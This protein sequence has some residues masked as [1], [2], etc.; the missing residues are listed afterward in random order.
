M[1]TN[2]IAIPIESGGLRVSIDNAAGLLMRR[3]ESIAS[4][5]CVFEVVDAKDQEKAIGTM[6]QLAAVAS[7]VE[8]ARKLVKGPLLDL[9]RKIDAVCKEFVDDV[10]REKNRIAKLAADWQALED[11]KR[12]AAE[13]AARMEQERIAREAMRAQIE[14]ER[15][16]KLESDRIERERQAALAAAKSHEDLDRINAEAGEQ[17]RR[18]AQ[19]EAEAK[20]RAEY[21][22]AQ[23]AAAIVAPA[24]Q[25]QI[26]GQ[27][28]TQDWE[29]AVT[30]IHALYRSHPGCVKMT[31]LLGVIKDALNSGVKLQGITAQRITKVSVRTTRL[32]AIEA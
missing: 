12:R 4:A 25:Q 22:A 10:D 23:K 1:S 8:T 26:N 7:E 27:V 3:D 21:E 9:G 17:Q 31:P 16:A 15:A 29:I 14:A 5:M 28:T 32:G 2:A 13:A 20:E 6:K 11:A 30:D 18:L 24:V 19:A